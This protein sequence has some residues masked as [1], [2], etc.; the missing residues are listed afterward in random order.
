M[1]GNFY[2]RSGG[3]GTLDSPYIYSKCATGS[4]AQANTNYYIRHD[5]LEQIFEVMSTVAETMQ[6]LLVT[7][8]L[9]LVKRRV[10]NPPLLFLAEYDT[11]KN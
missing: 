5:E 7:L 4:K 1:V 2:I 10:N 9:Q 11:M 8:L 6:K 3:E